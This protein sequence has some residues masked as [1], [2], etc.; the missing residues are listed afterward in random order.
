VP[1][2]ATVRPNIV[3]AEADGLVAARIGAVRREE[4]DV[5]GLTLFGRSSG[6]DRRHPGPIGP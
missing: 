5:L 6:T 4:E 2:A 1:V 3:R